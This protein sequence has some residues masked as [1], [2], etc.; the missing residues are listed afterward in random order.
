VTSTAN[1]YSLCTVHARRVVATA[2][3]DSAEQP[4]THSALQNPI[5]KHIP[6]PYASIQ[7]Q[8]IMRQC[9]ILTTMKHALCL[10]EEVHEEGST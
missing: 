8:S 9:N 3:F 6:D 5:L 10:K 1:S 7:G 4:S 2:A